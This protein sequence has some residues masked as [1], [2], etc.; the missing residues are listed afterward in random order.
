MSGDT[1]GIAPLLSTF[2]IAES[3]TMNACPGDFLLP[4]GNN[5]DILGMHFLPF[6][7]EINRAAGNDDSRKLLTI[8]GGEGN[9][10]RDV[11]PTLQ[12]RAHT[13]STLP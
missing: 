2:P 3:G 8:R 12:T 7:L 11:Q 10:P 5:I 13:D 4:I 6:L 1:L 9:Q